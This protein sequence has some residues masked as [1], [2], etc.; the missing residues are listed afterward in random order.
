MDRA[1]LLALSAY[2]PAKPALER[3]HNAYLVRLQITGRSL[4]ILAPVM[5]ANKVE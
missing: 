1:T 4:G 5:R 2:I 3:L